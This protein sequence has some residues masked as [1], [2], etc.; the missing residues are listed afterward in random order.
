MLVAAALAASLAACDGGASSRCGTTEAVVER[1]IDGDTIE[2]VGGE[3]IRYLMVNA[4]ET[5]G[6]KNECYGTNAV[7][8]NTDLVR[9]KLVQLRHDIDCEDQFGR[10]LAYVSVNGQEVNTLL[11]ERGYACIL[12]IPPN[13]DDRADE[14]EAL[15]DTA[16]LAKRGLWGACDPIPCN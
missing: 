14:L 16:R 10:T 5:T 15:E 2:L 13:G 8:F 9:G 7:T 12:H 6:G 1:V 3:R 4:P 11:I